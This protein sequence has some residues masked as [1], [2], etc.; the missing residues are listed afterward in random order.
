MTNQ[1]RLQ[2]NNAEIEAIKELVETKMSAPPTPLYETTGDNTDGAMTQEAST[3]LFAQKSEIP[4]TSGFITDSQLQAKIDLEATARV[5]KDNELARQ[6]STLQNKHLYLHTIKLGVYGQGY[7]VTNIITS[8]NSQFTFA[9]V[10]NWLYS[11][12][13]TDNGTSINNNN[14][15]YPC[16]GAGSS[17]SNIQSISSDNGSSLRIYWGNYMQEAKVFSSV[18]TFVDN[19]VQ[20]I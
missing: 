13:F 10:S 17:S 18:D 8:S 3:R 2:Q 4:D 19:V 11:N 1:E 5:N 15:R 9:S 12:G 14:K 20:I 7:L 16:S 6:I